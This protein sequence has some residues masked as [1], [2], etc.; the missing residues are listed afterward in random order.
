MTSYSY[1]EYNSELIPYEME[2]L[3][4]HINK[5]PDQNYQKKISSSFKILNED[6]KSVSKEQ[7]FFLLKSHIYQEILNSDSLKRKSGNIQLSLAL[8]KSLKSKLDQNILI[9]SEFSQWIIIGF[10]NDLAPFTQDG[11]LDRYESVKQTN[12]KEFIRQKNLK[13]ILNYISPII[14]LFYR[15]HPQNFN[16]SISEIA[17]KAV[18]KLASKSYYYRNFSSSPQNTT[19]KDL[20][21][22]KIEIAPI[23][24]APAQGEGEKLKDKIKDLSIDPSKA[25]E[26][27]DSLDENNDWE[28]STN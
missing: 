21:F 17:S 2:L 9:Y 12:Q 8:I 23:E 28:P 26:L 7:V 1:Y 11:F 6:L 24:P 15:L 20:F 19:G 22:E 13:K 4:K 3:I 18:I 14:D 25:S 10:F 27:I 16:E 5:F